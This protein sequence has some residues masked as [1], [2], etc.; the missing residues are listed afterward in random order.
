[1]GFFC[2]LA[3]VGRTD[4]FLFD[5]PGGRVV[6]H[7]PAAICFSSSTRAGRRAITF[8]PAVFFFLFGPFGSTSG[9]ALPSLHTRVCFVM[10]VNLPLESRISQNYNRQSAIKWLRVDYG[11]GYSQRAL[12]GLNAVAEQISLS[13]E[14]VTVAESNQIESD[15]VAS[16][17][18]HMLFQGKKFFVESYSITVQSG[19]LN[20]VSVS[21][22][23]T[24]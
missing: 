4:D 9:V 10:S 3:K 17:S 18:S 19:E 21:M 12:N 24:F 1:M 15:I 13:W 11:D 2:F 16:L 7:F 14:N 5:W 22:T 6:I 20:T 23:Q 8:P